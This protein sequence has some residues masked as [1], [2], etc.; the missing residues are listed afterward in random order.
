VLFLIL[1]QDA[2]EPLRSKNRHDARHRLAHFDEA[3]GARE[4]H[5]FVSAA[6]AFGKQHIFL[7]QQHKPQ[8]VKVVERLESQLVNFPCAT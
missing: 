5:F 7:F 6:L 4:S 8:R 3:V 1:L 2:T